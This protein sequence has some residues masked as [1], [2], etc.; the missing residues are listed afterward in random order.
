MNIVLFIYNP[1]SG[2][3]YILMHLDYIIEEYQK[4]GYCLIPFR[5]TIDSR[6]SDLVELIQQPY[7]HILISGG[8]G[9]VN[10]VVNILMNNSINTPIAVL[11]AGTAN[12]FAKMLGNNLGIKDACRKILKGKVSRIDVGKVNSTYFVNVLSAG[13][14]TEVSQRTPT[15]LKNTFGK[16]AYYMN[17]INELPRFRMMHLNVEAAEGRYNDEAVIFF[18]FNGR[19]AGNLDIAHYSD[20]RDGL[21]DVVIIKNNNPIDAVNVFIHFFTNPIIKSSYPSGV[22][23]FKTKELTINAISGDIRIDIDGEQ[24]PGLPLKISCLHRALR[25]IR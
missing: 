9:T 6:E 7:H 11:P 22:V 17:S 24:G 8:D 12:D 23:H 10:L 4:A 1:F 20:E 25:V 19:T 3:N 13:L 18:V 21:L 14:F 2:E 15:M 16:M 5:F